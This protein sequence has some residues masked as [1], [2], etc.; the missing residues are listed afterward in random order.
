MDLLLLVSLLFEGSGDKVCFSF[1]AQMP[2]LVEHILWASSL[3]STFDP[4]YVSLIRTLKPCSQREDQKHNINK[5]CRRVRL[6]S[7]LH[8]R[9]ISEGL[10]ST[11]GSVLW[12][13]MSTGSHT[14]TFVRWPL[15]EDL[16]TSHRVTLVLPW[17]GSDTWTQYCLEGPW[18]GHGCRDVKHQVQGTDKMNR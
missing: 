6:G 17:P 1:Q 16:A 14:Q 18:E 11:S 3:K 12:A 4:L 5:I 9:L 10:S 7:H 2:S 8:L 13:S 15:W